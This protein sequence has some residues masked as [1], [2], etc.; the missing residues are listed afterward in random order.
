LWIG[1]FFAA[2]AT[3]AGSVS[4]VAL[5]DSDKNSLVRISF[6]TRTAT[7]IANN[8]AGVDLALDADGN[9]V[10][11]AKS[12]LL[13]VTPAGKVAVIAKA[14]PGAEWLSVAVAPDG[15]IFAADGMRPALWRVSADG[16]SVIE[17]A[18]WNGV[19]HGGGRPVNVRID[20]AGDC[21]VLIDGVNHRIGAVV[22]L[23]RISRAGVVTQVPV[24]GPRVWNPASMVP[25]GSG[26][27]LF[28]AREI[29]GGVYRLSIKDGV[30]HVGKLSDVLIEMV[31]RDP[32]TGATLLG[33]FTGG[34]AWLTESGDDPREWVRFRE[35]QLPKAVLA[36]TNR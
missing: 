34:W 31:V 26:G 4:Y 10:V 2:A 11:A 16:E 6:D 21:L 22:E 18:S 17:F 32:E 7:T 9:Y 27:W 25:D 12:A 28:V 29:L 33:S 3:P 35:V 1:A 23:W 8:A 15:N 20:G 19:H 14:P 30:A 5:Q 24:E 13:R 36:V